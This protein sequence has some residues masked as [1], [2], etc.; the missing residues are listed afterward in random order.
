ML[1][2]Q[3]PEDHELSALTLMVLI[4]IQRRGP[5]R[6]KDWVALALHLIAR[7]YGRTATHCGT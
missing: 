3:S 4:M 2:S 6:I 5:I 7:P 1:Q